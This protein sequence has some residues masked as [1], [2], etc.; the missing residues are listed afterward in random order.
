[1][2]NNEQINGLKD[3]GQNKDVFTETESIASS[4]LL[5]ELK[6][7]VLNPVCV[8]DSTGEAFEVYCAWTPFCLEFI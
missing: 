7:V 4:L 2:N 5:K 6:A 3:L 8:L 1:M